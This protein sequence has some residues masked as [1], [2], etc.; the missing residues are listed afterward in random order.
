M[1]A[2]GEFLRQSLVDQAVAVDSA[3]PLGE[4]AWLPTLGGHLGLITR[5]SYLGGNHAMVLWWSDWAVRTAEGRG[6][7]RSWHGP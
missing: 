3:L 5:D 6:S 4:S 1:H 2:A 7:R